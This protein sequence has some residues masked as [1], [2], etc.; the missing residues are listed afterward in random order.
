MQIFAF[1]FLGYHIIIQ[2][3][4]SSYSMTVCLFFYLFLLYP[5]FFKYINEAEEIGIP[6]DHSMLLDLHRTMI[7]CGHSSAAAQV[8]H[9]CFSY[10]NLIFVIIMFL[11]FNYIDIWFVIS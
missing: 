6:L 2:Y 3:V 11:S 8:R 9:S 10:Q 5:N 7:T 4:V 1:V